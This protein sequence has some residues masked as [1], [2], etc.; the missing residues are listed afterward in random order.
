MMIVV[1]QKEADV[2]LVQV[3]F[4]T[5]AGLKVFPQGNVGFY[6]LN[7]GIGGLIFWEG[8]DSSSVVDEGE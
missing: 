6:G 4:A 5:S 7:R 8:N 2:G 1:P 3:Q